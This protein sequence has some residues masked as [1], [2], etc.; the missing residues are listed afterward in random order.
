M[1]K[2][3]ATAGSSTQKGDHRDGRSKGAEK[4]KKV[5]KTSDLSEQVRAM[6]GDDSDLA[7]LSGV[8]DEQLVQGTQAVDVRFLLSLR[9]AQLKLYHIAQLGEGPVRLYARIEPLAKDKIP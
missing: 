8:R 7:L 9:Y 3:H 2:S 4:K 1:A 6:G 5:K